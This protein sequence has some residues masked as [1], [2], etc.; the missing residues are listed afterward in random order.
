MYYL[1]QLPAESSD[2]GNDKSIR[3]LVNFL[4]R[5][6]AVFPLG[7]EFLASFNHLLILIF[8]FCKLFDCIF[9]FLPLVYLN[10][11]VC[12][13]LSYILIIKICFF[14]LYVVY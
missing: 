2:I 9:G 4:L 6:Q 14:I 3:R 12:K 8:F 10:M 1:H 7:E 13:Q 11:Y 5:L